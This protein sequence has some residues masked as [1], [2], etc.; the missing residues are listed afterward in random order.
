SVK[1]EIPIVFRLTRCAP[2]PPGEPGCAEI[3]DESLR[4]FVLGRHQAPFDWSELPVP[5]GMNAAT[6]NA[7][8]PAL[9]DRFGSTWG[10]LVEELG[11]IATRLSRRGENGASV[12]ALF[13]FA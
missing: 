9:A 2:C 11:A 13:R 6:W 12:Y 3:C 5:P 10:E 1:V 4:L 7:A 8:R